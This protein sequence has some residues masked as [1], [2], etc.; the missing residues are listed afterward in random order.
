MSNHIWRLLSNKKSLWIQW[1]HAYRI[2]DRNFWD[3]PV[4]YDASWSWRKLLSI[5]HLVRKFFFF[6]V[7]NGENI[8]VWFD[9]WCENGPLS[10]VIS[11][12]S[13]HAA[14]F[15]PND[16]LC[17]IW[18]N[19]AWTW[20]IERHNLY[21]VINNTNQV[22]IRNTHDRL[23]WRDLSGNLCPFSVNIAWNSIRHCATDVDWFYIVWFA[24]CIPRHSFVLWLAM[25]N[26]LKTHDLTT[27]Q[28][29][30]DDH[31]ILVWDRVRNKM[32][33]QIQ[34]HVCSDVASELAHITHC[35]SARVIEAKLL[36]G[37]SVYFLWQERNARIF[38]NQTR[39][40]DKL[41]EVIFS[42][43]RLKFMSLRWK[44]SIQAQTLK[45]SWK[46]N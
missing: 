25:G 27:R 34:Q 46:I 10:E 13:I 30:L 12:R 11:R 43:V 23:C 15:H 17:D 5:H 19:N 42:T 37:A 41:M 18:H 4:P 32:Q 24:H 33:L 16:K 9:N 29:A 14:G 35:K 39:S 20:P 38:K 28:S 1:I 7:G 40:V 44:N 31:H 6:E 8:S 2:G 45:A 21:H 26:R 36:L 22:I 3:L